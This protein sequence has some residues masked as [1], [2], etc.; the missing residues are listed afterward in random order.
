MSALR[1]RGI[2]VIP[3][4]L[5]L[6]SCARQD[7]EI[8][9]G[10]ALTKIIV[11]M[12][13][14]AQAEQGGYYEAMTKG[15]YRDAGLDVSIVQAGPE[16]PIDLKLATGVVQFGIGRADDT[17]VAIARDI[18]VVIVSALMEH[19][20]QAVLLHEDSPVKSF[21]DLD[22]KSVMTVPGSYWITYMEK[23]FHEKIG[24]IPLN[25]GLAQ[26]MSDP[27]YIQQCFLTSE[28]YYVEQHGGHSRVMLF[29]EAGY[30]FYRVLSGNVDWINKHRAQTRAF[31]AASTKGWYE[32]LYGDPTPANREIL[33]DNLQMK[34]EFLDY[35]VMA[36]K[37]YKLVSGD[38]AKGEAIGRLSRDRL[39]TQI[40]ILSSLGVLDH[41]V[42]VDEI[43]DLSLSQ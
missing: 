6:A 17:I 41:P 25:F 37:K 29:S 11:Q 32:Y 5:V 27:N 4:L 18:P 12:D 9:N 1:R 21:K 13:W 38:P 24:I 3:A 19:D 20:L 26:F 30:D 15:Y 10:R 2:W 28:P 43:A 16:V 33:A 35:A 8:V 42:T 36:L 23:T 7:T 22:G 34:Q 39:Q 31:I 14:Y 40:N